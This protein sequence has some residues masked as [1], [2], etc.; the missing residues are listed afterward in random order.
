MI[1]NKNKILTILNWQYYFANLYNWNTQLFW[2]WRDFPR[3]NND[4]KHENFQYKN[5]NINKYYKNENK[6][7]LLLI[8]GGLD[9]SNNGSYIH[10]TNHFT[11][12]YDVIFYNQIVNKE[13]YRIFGNKYDNENFINNI[14]ENYD[15]VFL[16]GF[17]AGVGSIMKYII[18]NPEHPKI[19]G[20]V[21]ISNLILPFYFKTRGTIP[22]SIFRNFENN[23]KLNKNFNGE[24]CDI[25]NH[26]EKTYHD[27]YYLKYINDYNALNEDFKKIKYQI[28]YLYARD[29]DF[30][31]LEQ[32]DAQIPIIKDTNISFL[33]LD[34]GYH[35]L[36]MNNKGYTY[37]PFVNDMMK[38]VFSDDF[39][40]S[41][42]IQ[43][44]IKLLLNNKLKI[45]K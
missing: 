39:Y 13:N 15:K 19:K 36:F 27:S 25:I 40:P 3:L 10:M 8:S 34:R 38:I 6:K 45:I 41:I 35:T 14:I 4:I 9:F 5:I 7:E 18:D 1:I 17:S 16:M 44:K 37:I 2:S 12:N 11:N 20:C 30:I 29:D 31:P 28:V 42:K 33:L 43:K 24:V 32:L 23:L 21:N 26:L 22:R